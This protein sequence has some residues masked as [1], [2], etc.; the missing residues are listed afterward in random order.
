M[1]EALIPVPR[2]YRAPSPTTRD[3]VA[4]LFRQRR[5]WVR[6]FV[7]IFT[8]SILYAVLAA[9]YES[10]M[11]IV[12]RHRRVDP[13]LTAAPTGALQFSRDE[14]TE[15]EL[16]SEADLLRDQE[17][18]RAVIQ[19]SELRS[20]RTTWIDKILGDS[21]E[22]HRQRL[23]RRLNQRLTVAPLKKATL[24]SVSYRDSDPARANSVLN[25]LGA[26]YLERHSRIQRPIGESAFFEQQILTARQNLE[27]AEAEMMKFSNQEGVV[28][29]AFE[30]DAKLQK[31]SE[32]EASEAQTRIALSATAKRITALES[33]LRSLPERVT[34][35]IRNSDNPLLLQKLKS[36]LLDLQLKR[37]ELLTKYEP[38]YRLVQEVDKQ[39]ADTRAVLAAEDQLPLRDETTERDS[40]H[41]WVKAELVKSQVEFSSEAEKL[42]ATGAALS[43]YRKSAQ[44]LGN[45]A[46]QQE[47]LL[48]N[49]K[50]AEDK[51]LLYVNKKEEARIAD[52]LDQDGIVNVAI[53]QQPTIPVLPVRS[54]FS[55]GFVGLLLAGSVSTGAAFVA[56]YA[57]PALRTP[58]E[59][60]FYLG[61]PVLASLP[62]QTD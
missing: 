5:L 6:C 37:T 56:D 4:V 14:I 25:A 44:E 61:I 39:I 28:S 34:T 17:I 40:N 21:E 41:E 49:L 11:K 7:A 33:T 48:R 12:V 42:R 13:V 62:R 23:I 16:N 59:V 53:V 9:S 8:V 2:V 51:Y 60:M 29:A 22:V 55:V 47:Q 1:S 35:Q 54:A 10:Q 38:S 36:T 58:D 26:A 18:L 31:I 46:I 24:I 43:G 45:R 52:A 27:E 50:G 30:R 57:D 15:E 3:I 20:D 19:N 32:A